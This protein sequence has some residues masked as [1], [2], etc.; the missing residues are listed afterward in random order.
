MKTLD[1]LKQLSDYRLIA[2]KRHE[3]PLKRPLDGQNPE[4]ESGH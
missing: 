4:V 3:W 1:N 2:R